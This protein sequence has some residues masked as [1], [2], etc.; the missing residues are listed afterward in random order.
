[1]MRRLE[2]YILPPL[3]LRG[4]TVAQA[5]NEIEKAVQ[6]IG[7]DE[8]KGAMPP[9]SMTESELDPQEAN[10]IDLSLSPEAVEFE[11]FVN[12]GSPIRPAGPSSLYR[13]NLPLL[14]TLRYLVALDGKQ[15]AFRQT[16]ITAVPAPP[17]TS[18]TRSARYQIPP[19]FLRPR[20][21][22]DFRWSIGFDETEPTL[23][24]ADLG[25]RL[26]E[27]GIELK[28]DP[29]SWDYDSSSSS[30]TLT[31]TNRDHHVLKAV[32]ALIE[33][34]QITKQINFEAKG[35]ELSQP[36]DL[37]ARLDL[38]SPLRPVLAGNASRGMTP[39]LT[40]PQH[41]TFIEAYTES[42]GVTS[43]SYPK[44]VSTLG[45]IA[46]IRSITNG[47]EDHLLAT[48]WR[49]E[50]EPA[51]KPWSGMKLIVA[52]SLI[53]EKIQLRAD[54]ELRGEMVGKAEDESFIYDGQLER[55][56]N[57]LIGDGETMV[58]AGQFEGQDTSSTIVMMVTV[59]LIDPG[60]RPIQ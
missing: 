19:D 31:A 7:F 5:F 42:P 12:Y 45:R 34:F 3:D 52:G 6:E 8:S 50:R 35:I 36:R 9:I 38:D 1:M 53:G 47:D 2:N 14:A 41:E 39:I 46:E 4:R 13:E 49:D 18:E 20:M 25:T 22:P 57:Q 23:P 28:S 37:L 43:V 44:V 11:G 16:S 59:S 30:I 21:A 54:W 58:L 56:G 10:E 29:S 55:S 17:S 26:R 51:D 60:R 40:A 24:D 15:L 48:G 27:W 32:L 33:K